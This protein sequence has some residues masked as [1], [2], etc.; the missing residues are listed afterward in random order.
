MPFLTRLFLKTGLIYLGAGFTFGALMLANKGIT[1]YPALWRL[2]PVHIEF[3]LIGWMVQLAL[4]VAHWILPRLWTLGR[5]D[6]RF[7][8]LAYGLL[9]GGIWLVILASLGVLPP[10]YLFLGR[11][12]EAA[13]ALTFA[14]HLWP[15]IVARN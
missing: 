11:V 4:G 3:L 15:R 5:G 6:T 13:A 10:F 14:V 7:V 9:N 12:A 1:F 2:L 8:W